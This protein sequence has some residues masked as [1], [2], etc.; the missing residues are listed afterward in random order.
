MGFGSLVSGALELANSSSTTSSS[1]IGG[2]NEGEG[3]LMAIDPSSSSSLTV[4]ATLDNNSSN[5]KQKQTSSISLGLDTV[6]VK[7]NFANK[8]MKKS[9]LSSQTRIKV[10]FIRQRIVLPVP[11]E[12]SILFSTLKST[13]AAAAF[14]S[15]KSNGF[16][17]L[18]RRRQ[19]EGLFL[20]QYIRDRYV[21]IVVGR[22]VVEQIR[23]LMSLYIYLLLSSVVFS[24]LPAIL[25]TKLI[26]F[27]MHVSIL[28]MCVC[29]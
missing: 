2:N 28:F 12:L 5:Y 17:D 20:L 11:I 23:L 13:T 29:F 18:T 27:I 9:D 10:G 19:A 15:S 26:I 16:D 7:D 24:S 8:V 25:L 22:M 1:H 21:S 3:S 4:A 14:A 6:L